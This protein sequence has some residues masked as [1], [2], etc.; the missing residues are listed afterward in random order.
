MI[1]EHPI[2]LTE[3]PGPKT[4]PGPAGEPGLAAGD[5]RL[6]QDRL[7]IKDLEMQLAA[8]RRASQSMVDEV[9]EKNDALIREVQELRAARAAEAK[10][11]A[12]ASEAEFRA[13]RATIEARIDRHLRRFEVEAAEA[14]ATRLREGLSALVPALTAGAGDRWAGVVQVLAET[15]LT[16][17]GRVSGPLS[18][19]RL[20]H[21]GE[22]LVK[23][24]LIDADWYLEQNPGVKERGSDPVEHYLRHGARE[25]RTPAPALSLPELAEAEARLS[26]LLAVPQTLDEVLASAEVIPESSLGAARA[27]AEPHARGPR[28]SVVIPTYNRATTIV[29]AVSSA[30]EQSV[31]PYEVIVADDQSTDNTVALL[32]ERFAQA[33]K[34]GRLVLM[35]CEKG[36]VCKMRNAALARAD[37]DVIAYLDSDN[38]W[39]RD[40]LLWALAALETGLAPSVYTAANIHHLTEGWSRI[41]STPYDRRKILGQNFID[42]NCF[43][44]RA[45]LYAAHGGFDTNL[46]RLV[47]WDF[48]LR[49]T[50]DAPPLRVPVATVEYFL[51]KESLSN[52][53][54]VSSLEENAIKIQLKHR[55]EMTAQGTLNENAQRKLDAA[56]ARMRGESPA[57]PAQPAPAPK[58]VAAKA[59]LKPRPLPASGVLP[60]F[61]GLN[62]FVALPEGVAPPD[63]LPLDFVEPR[64]ITV[65][66]NGSWRE[67]SAAGKLGPS[68]DKLPHG[69]YWCPDLRQPLPTPHQ[70]ATLAGAT[71]LTRI[72]LAVGSFSLDMPPAVGVSCFRNQLVMRENL[73]ADYLAGRALPPLTGKVLRIPE[74]KPDRL[75]MQDLPAL[76]G[77][78]VLFGKDGQT[79]TLGRGEAPE[80]V[81]MRRQ[82]DPHP[83]V[84]SKTR[85]RVLVLAQKLAVGGV[86][87]N[88]VEVTRQLK[89]GHECLYLTLEKIGS[90]QGSLCHQATEACDQVLDLAEIGHHGIFQELL[91]HLNAVYQP[92]NLW[93]C[94]GSM[95]LAGNAP[96]FRD[97]F[98]DCG[99]VDQQVYDVDAG[100]INRYPEPGIQSFDRFIAINRKINEKFVKSFG[101]DP[102]RIDLIYSAINAQRFR[103]ARA[104][105]FDRDTQRDAFGLP[106]GK[107]IFTF[108]GR[109]VEQKRPMDFLEVARLS[110]ANKDQHFVLV[111]NGVLAGAVEA[112]LERHKPA[113]V[114][115]IKNVPDTTEYWPAVDAYLVTSEYE[116][117]PIALIEA[118][119]LGVPAI[120]TDVG[121][122]R[123]V[124]D[125]YE[126][127]RVVDKWGEPEAFAKVLQGFAPDLA[128]S[129]KALKARG[130]EIIDFFSAEAISRQFADCFKKARGRRSSNAGFG[131]DAL[132]QPREIRGAGGEERAGSD[133]PDAGAGGDRR[134]LEG[135]FGRAVEGH[136]RP[137]SEAGGA[138]EP[139]RPCRDQPWARAGPGRLPG[140]DQFR[141]YLRPHAGGRMPEGAG[142]RADRFRLHLDPRGGRCRQREGHQAGLEEHA[143]VLVLGG[144]GPCLLAGRGFRAEP[145]GDEFRLD[146]LE[147]AVPPPALRRGRRDAQSAVLA[148]LGFHAAPGAGFRLFG[149]AATAD[150]LPAA[151]V[152]HDLVEPQMDAV[153]GGL[154]HR[155]QPA[156]L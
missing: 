3:T 156:P 113:N 67:W 140:G 7:R 31:P 57:V 4:S 41:D 120:A 149:G 118:I 33:L 30:L 43:V 146:H 11:P 117:L 126:A 138:G 125:K 114:T 124:L 68:N 137:A 61:G 54:F 105:G 60:Y 96:W 136:R 119:S 111:G 47:D 22:A 44:H 46:T 83:I 94:N 80:P 152:E 77:Q 10:A 78:E 52:I 69:N 155:R 128:A 38:Y 42:L 27:E 109:L 18:Q 148:R 62:L 134:R 104:A 15:L 32:E 108:M 132:I 139:G 112:Y 72:E 9:R 154:D 35:R 21:A 85:P 127:G 135:Q 14:R 75:R 107:Q 93:I 34:D 131:G 29:R 88:T 86:E 71:Q 63:T 13:A 1:K 8:L 98:K 115:W 81:G 55:A 87:R 58:P 23:A 110:E 24:G 142:P 100:W 6:V 48:I 74:G 49:L 121:D 36:G 101:M 25:R 141:R 56:E 90:E 59:P 150:G 17:N 82:R 65:A 129:A 73:V 147:H 20:A 99:I 130:G 95:W 26:G 116:G 106:R 51:D 37:G 70:L 50:R 40:H 145:A 151:R 66:E 92:D 122:I 89:P 12:S 143:P 2:P 39:H 144:E 103:D 91:A 76:L 64:W 123:Y 79:F 53:S 153:R 84:K 5:L 45:E 102:G 133:P 28:V 97:T 16:E 19:R